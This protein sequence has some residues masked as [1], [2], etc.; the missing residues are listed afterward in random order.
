[1]CLNAQ[2]SKMMLFVSP[3]GVKAELSRRKVDE[4]IGRRVRV[5]VSN[6]INAKDG[7]QRQHHAS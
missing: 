3:N 5:N 6:A 2:H 7:V 4:L 1:M